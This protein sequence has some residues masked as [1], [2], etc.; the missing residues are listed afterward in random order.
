MMCIRN[1]KYMVQPVASYELL[2]Y[3]ASL[4]PGLP[5]TAPRTP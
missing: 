5:A 4:H 2:E 1:T 3:V